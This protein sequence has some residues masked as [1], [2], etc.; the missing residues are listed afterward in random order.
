M[1]VFA[2][3]TL[4]SLNVDLLDLQRINATIAFRG[5]FGQLASSRIM[6]WIKRILSVILLISLI[7]FFWPLLGEIQAARELL[8]NANWEWLAIAIILQVIS[9]AFLTWLNALSLQPFP[10]SIGFASLAAVLSSMAFIQVAVPS[11]G[12]SGVYLRVRFL[13]KFGYKSEVGLFSMFVETAAEGI[14][15]F[16][17]SMI[18]VAYLIR[19]GQ[20]SWFELGS[21]TLVTLAFA[22]L[23]W[24]GW[25]LLNDRKR[26]PIFLDKFARLWNRYFVRFRKF[27]AEDYTE[28][29]SDFQTNLVQFRQVPMWKF[30]ISAFGKV[31]F[32]VATMGAT[33]LMVGYSVPIG[34]LLIGYGLV[35]LFNSLTILPG[36]LGTADAFVPVIFS[37]FNVPGSVALTAGLTYR[38]IT[39]WLL[40]FIGY[41][42]WHIL[43]AAEPA[44]GDEKSIT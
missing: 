34:T 37:W 25:R 42:C 29:L 28:R 16:A 38:L 10:G 18:G 15:L 19:S 27:D 41:I 31:V 1:A 4:P 6:I 44:G 12:A 36:G 2:F 13:G 21:L 22:G 35:M 9:Y 24:Y 11:G 8:R 3:R 7:Y 30:G 32:D 26:S 43:E 33:F 5:I 17:A 20:F 39:F 14:I 23:I 40:R